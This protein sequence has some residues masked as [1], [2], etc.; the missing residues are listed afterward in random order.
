MRLE[1]RAGLLRSARIAMLKTIA[2]GGS[3]EDGA[4]AA[5]EVLS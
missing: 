2:A 3:I 4:T 5:E 1:T